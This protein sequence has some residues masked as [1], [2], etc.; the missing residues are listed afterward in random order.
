MRTYLIIFSL[1]ENRS[2]SIINRIKARWSWARITSTSWCV[3]TNTGIYEI[4]DELS[5]GTTDSERILIVDISDSS[6]AS[7]NLPKEVSKWLKE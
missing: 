4:R 6:W 1:N 3:K 7:R 2:E 5:V